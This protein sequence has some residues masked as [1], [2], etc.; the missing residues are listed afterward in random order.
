MNDDPPLETLEEYER[1][2]EYL[3]GQDQEMMQEG[4][5]N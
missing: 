5:E 3:I 2:M 4:K 1:E